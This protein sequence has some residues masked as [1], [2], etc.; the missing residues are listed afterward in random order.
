MPTAKKTAAPKTAAKKKAPAKK[1]APA[2]KKAPAKKAPAKKPAAKKSA[3]K[4]APAPAPAPAVKV[5][6]PVSVHLHT[7]GGEKTVTF[8]DEFRFKAAMTCIE[9]APSVSTG[10][11]RNPTYTIHADQGPVSFQFVRKYSIKS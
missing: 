5:F 3:A 7:N 1:R 2:K 8:S 9:S 6:A 4:P 10:A 11:R